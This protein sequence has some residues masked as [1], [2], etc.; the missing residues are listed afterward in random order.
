M[1]IKYDAELLKAMTFFENATHAKLKDC[2]LDSHTDMM[3]FVVM[4]GEIGKAVGKGGSNV[5]RLEDAFKKRIKIAEY[6]D[7][8]LQFVKNMIMPLRVEMAEQ[9]DDVVVLHDQDIKTKGLLIGR[10]AGNLR[11]LEKNVQRF[12]PALKEIKVV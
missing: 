6:A 5:R 7:D 12:F 2:Y 4:P 8:L 10:N 11:N 1:T 9:V 3:T